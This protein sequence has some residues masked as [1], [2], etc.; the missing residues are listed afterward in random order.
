MPERLKPTKPESATGTL[1][2]RPR[3]F[4]RSAL[5][6][7]DPEKI[8][9]LVKATGKFS[10]AE[11]AIAEELALERLKKG[12]ASGYSFELACQGETVVGYACYGPIP[13]S[14]TSWDLYWIAVL[15]KRQAEGMG[16]AVLNR[17]EGI[18]RRAGGCFL[19]ADTSSS[20]TYA[21]T[22]AFYQARGFELVAEFPDFYRVGDG[23][24][25]FVR[26]LR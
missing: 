10:N 2:R 8:R 12:P 13:A 9:R 6:R 19:Y 21:A 4:W 16:T 14:K 3:I 7:R 15:P 20:D 25:V 24:S 1:L 17:V 5:G 18:V 11:Q 23:K 22:R 26:D